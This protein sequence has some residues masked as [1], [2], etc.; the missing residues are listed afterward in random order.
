MGIESDVGPLIEAEAEGI[1]ELTGAVIVEDF[2][3]DDTF[4]AYSVR[5]CF[6]FDPLLSYPSCKKVAKHSRVITAY[7]FI[8]TQL[9][10]YKNEVEFKYLWGLNNLLLP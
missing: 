10:L 3:P 7:I 9:L 8:V 4:V 6:N 2:G 1:E 5:Y